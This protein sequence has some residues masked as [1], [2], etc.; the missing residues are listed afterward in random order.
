MFDCLKADNSVGRS[1]GSGNQTNQPPLEYV[2]AVWCRS[3]FIF[4]QEVHLN[5]V[6]EPI[7]FTVAKDVPR[8]GVQ[9]VWTTL[10][11]HERVVGLVMN[12]PK[13]FGCI[14]FQDLLEGLRSLDCPMGR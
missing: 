13:A 2:R 7:Y 4:R 3:L 12:I 14:S 9:G 11:L 8:E 6:L 1:D 5:K 10:K